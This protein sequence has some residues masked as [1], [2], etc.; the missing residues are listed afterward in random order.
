M[1]AGTLAQRGHAIE[2]RV[3]AEDPA[4]GFLPQAGPLLLYREPRGPGIRVDSGYVEGNEVS[5]FY[6]PLLA[7][8]IVWA[9]TRDIAR[10]GASQRCA[11]YF[12]LG[13]PTN[14]PFLLQVLIIPPS[15]RARWTPGFLDRRRRRARCRPGSAGRGSRPPRLPPRHARD[16]QHGLGTSARAAAP[17]NDPFESLRGWRG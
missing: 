5:V 1:D 12:I 10:A 13:I 7:K 9:E 4:Q 11:S 8:L 2:C 14:V 16:S 3:Y 17:A 15:S 6:D